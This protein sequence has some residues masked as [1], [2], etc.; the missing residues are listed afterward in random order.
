MSNSP[1]ASAPRYQKI[2]ELGRNRA[3]GR[4]TYLAR[5]N[6]TGQLVVIKQF[7]FATSSS[8]W[9]GF[10]AYEREIQVLSSL[11]H[12]GIPRYLNSLETSAGFCLVQEY[13]DAQPLT[14]SRQWTSQEIK[15]IAICVLEIL[16]Y[17]QNRIPPVI[18]R[19]IK[20]ENILVDEQLNVYLVDFG[21]ARIGSGEGAISSVAAGTFGFMAPEQLYNRELTEATDLYGLGATLICLLTQTK[22]NAIETLID[23]TGRI[24]FKHRLPHL[25]PRFIDWLEKMVQPKQKE[26]YVSAAAAK[27][28]L[29]LLSV[30]PVPEVQISQSSLQFKASQLGEKVTQTITVNNSTPKTILEGHWAVAPHPHDPP[31]NSANQAW[32]SFTPIKFKGNQIDC[33]IAV[34]TS[35]LMANKVYTR[36]ILLQTNSEPAIQNLTVEVYTGSIALPPRKMLKGSLASIIIS[37]FLFHFLSPATLLLLIKLPSIFQ[38]IYSVEALSIALLFPSVI[39]AII[40]ILLWSILGFLLGKNRGLI[41][42]PIAI[43]ASSVLSPLGTLIAIAANS[44]VVYLIFSKIPFLRQMLAML[45]TIVTTT[46]IFISLSN[47]VGFLVKE[48]KE[49]GFASKNVISISTLATVLGTSSGLVYVPGFYNFFVMF[50]VIIMII[51]S[52]LLTTTI[53]DSLQKRRKLIAQYHQSEPNRIKP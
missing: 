47:L 23:N 30:A 4:I 32:I 37:L 28:V 24:K 33:S 5:D 31:P 9:S 46:G 42:I 35:N 44:E 20:P 53:R 27:E 29:S 7:Q 15:E 11:N 21:F 8:T 34:D 18:H 2:R 40:S 22:S 14:V 52:V 36:Q 48:H 26:R 6:T 16:V 13:K 43:V 49:A 3:G 10:K 1:K 41:S 17:L 45:L 50:A 51:S 19:D 39:A 38:L 12:P 25:S